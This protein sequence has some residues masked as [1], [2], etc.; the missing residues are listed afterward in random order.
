VK[1]AGNKRRDTETNRVLADQ[2]WT[3]VRCWEHEDL[4][5]VADRVV[6]LLEDKSKNRN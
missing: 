5:A 1:I 2:G 6:G 3:V 4:T